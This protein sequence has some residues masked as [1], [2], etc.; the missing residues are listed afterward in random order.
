M[1]EGVIGQEDRLQALRSAILASK[2]TGNKLPHM[3]FLGQTG[4]GKTHL[5]R[6]VSNEVDRP[7]HVLHAPSVVERSTLTD[8]IIEAD[9]GVLFI[10]EIH[11]LPRNMAEDL[12]TVFDDGLV[13]VETPVTIRQLVA[14]QINDESEI[15]PDANIEWQGGGFYQVP[16]DIPTKEVEISTV[17]VDL[18]IIGAT[19]DESF[20]PDAF[21]RRLSG[22]KVF[23]RSYQLIELATIARLYADDMSIGL[24]NEAAIYLAERSRRNPARIKHLLLRAADVATVAE[25]EEVTLEAAEAALEALGVD[26]QGLE[27]PHRA[28]LK[29][30]RMT[31][32]SGLSRTSLGQMLNLTPK[33]LDHYW[34]DLIEQGLV[35]VDTRHRITQLGTEVQ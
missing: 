27:P 3:L 1:L 7:F 12:Y 21:L 32:T 34:G 5:A 10:D 6:A 30:L 15:P 16:M 31:G 28:I 23:L 4:L 2:A 26:S 17:A 25:E 29:A 19:T 8:K 13:T 14:V 18:T 33:N 11:A 24:T 9:G 35:T 20:L 22:L